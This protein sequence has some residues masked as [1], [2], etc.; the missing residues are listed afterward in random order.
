MKPDSSVAFLGPPRLPQAFIEKNGYD[1]RDFLY[2]L[3]DSREGESARVRYDF[4]QTLHL[5]L[6]ETYHKYNHDWCEAHGLKYVT[7]VPSVRMSN[8]LYSHVLGGDSAHEKI[9]RSLDWI[10][11]RYTTNM[12]ANPRMV[13]SLARQYGRSRALIEC[14]HSVGWS[15]TLQDAKWMIDRMA[16]MGINFFNFHAFF[17]TLNGLRKYDA[18]PS[19][20]YQNPYWK[21]FRKLA[22]YTG[23]ISLAMSQGTSIGS[24]ALL[25]PVTS[26]WSHLGNPLHRFAYCGN[27]E[28]ERKKLEKLL[29]DWEAICKTLDQNQKEYDH[30]DPEILAQA[31]IA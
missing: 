13:S 12:R 5:L 2:A 11:H 10:L 28:K 26:L 8:Q 6:R 14:F 18:P 3:V 1:I 4:F 25:V 7:E 21:D 19:Q 17:Y 16:A 27:D 15:M 30:L 29:H 23:R 31:E 20:F 22:D 24:T 9:G